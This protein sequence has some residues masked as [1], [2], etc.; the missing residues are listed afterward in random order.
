MQPTHDVVLWTLTRN[1]QQAEAVLRTIE[2]IGCELRLIWNGDLR[3]SQVYR[4]GGEVQA[5]ADERWRDLQIRGWS[6]IAEL[7]G[8]SS[9]T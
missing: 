3:F 4:D 6:E 5:A 2:N 1:G 9:R 8:G 7:P